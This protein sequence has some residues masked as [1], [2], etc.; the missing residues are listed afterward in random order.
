MKNQAQ[1]KTK[2]PARRLP[3]CPHCSKAIPVGWTECATSLKQKGFPVP[4]L[5]ELAKKFK[6]S[7]TLSSGVKVYVYGDGLIT[8]DKALAY[9]F[10]D[11]FD[12]DLYAERMNEVTNKNRIA[13]GL[14][15]YLFSVEE[16]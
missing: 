6:V 5:Q 9:A 11:K 10:I 3:R 2:N 16:A 4:G 12:A 14:E 7:Y 13:G 15:P 1:Q 8:E